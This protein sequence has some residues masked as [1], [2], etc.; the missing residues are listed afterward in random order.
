M[1]IFVNFDFRFSKIRKCFGIVG[2]FVKEVVTF[3]IGFGFSVL[4]SIWEH[5]LKIFFRP[6]KTKNKRP[7]KNLIFFQKCEQFSYGPFGGIFLGCL[8]SLRCDD[9]IRRLKL[10]LYEMVSNATSARLEL[11]ELQPSH[12]CLDPDIPANLRRQGGVR[13]EEIQ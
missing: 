3:T 9:E 7:P 8:V 6:P 1:K 10:E 11:I 5:R 2:V 4:N 13:K 12:G